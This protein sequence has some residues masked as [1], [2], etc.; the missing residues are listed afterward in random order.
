MSRIISVVAARTVSRL[1]TEAADARDW[2]MV[3]RLAAVLRY[4]TDVAENGHGDVSEVEA[5]LRANPPRV[6]DVGTV[7]A[8]EG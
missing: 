8:G 3:R 1:I 6:A 4:V 2:P 5:E 7:R